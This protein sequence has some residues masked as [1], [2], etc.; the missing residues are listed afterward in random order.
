MGHVLPERSV[1]WPTSA[2]GTGVWDLH[3]APVIQSGMEFGLSQEAG[4]QLPAGHR[5]LSLLRV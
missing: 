1:H 3:G 4:T 5:P 2:W